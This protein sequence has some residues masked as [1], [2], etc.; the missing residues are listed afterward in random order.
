MNIIKLEGYEEVLSAFND[1][2]DIFPN[3]SKRVNISEYIEKLAK[4]ANVYSIVDNDKHIGIAAVY[5]ND[6]ENRIAYLSLIGIT[7]EHRNDGLGKMLLNFCESEA[8]NAGMTALKLEVKKNNVAA[9]A[10]YGRMGYMII[11][12]SDS[13]NNYLQKEL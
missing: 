11:G 4:Y 10:L 5:M 3:L 6:F 12:E 13:G 8:I 1:V 7:K 9:N 2:K